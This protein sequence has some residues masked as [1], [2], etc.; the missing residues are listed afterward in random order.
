M[1]APE[2][3]WTPTAVRVEEANITRYQRWLESEHGLTF[4][5]YEA[6]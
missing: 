5:S 4:D 1:A 2:P 3:L 6:L